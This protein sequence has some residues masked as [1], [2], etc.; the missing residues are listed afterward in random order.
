[1]VVMKGIALWY[2]KKV[3]YTIKY[4]STQSTK[5]FIGLAPG[6]PVP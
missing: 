4:Y 6:G 1:M 2:S 3:Y 5:K